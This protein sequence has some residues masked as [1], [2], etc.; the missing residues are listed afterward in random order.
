MSSAKRLDHLDLVRAAIL[1]PSPDN[2]QPWRFVSRQGRL[3]V[4][5]DARQA[6]P[7]DVNAMCD[8]T[9][10]GAAVENACIAARAVGCELDVQC[11]K[12]DAPEATGNAN[13]AAATMTVTPGGTAD[14]LMPYLTMRCTCRRGFSTRPVEK[15]TLDRLTESARRFRQI[16]IDWIVDRPRIRSF[17]R[18]IAASDL[19]RFQYEPFHN[20]I[21]R[22]LRFSPEEAERTRDGLDLRALELPPGTGC[23]GCTGWGWDAC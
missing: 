15:A 1:A 18:L 2:N 16:Q 21:Y 8:L 9:G 6:L 13:V 5:L 11:G 4:H 7:S 17:A 14:P 22:Q 19:L 3:E 23:S 10:L 12:H 20:E